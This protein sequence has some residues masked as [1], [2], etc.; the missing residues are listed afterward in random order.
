M[1]SRFVRTFSILLAPLVAA[2]ALAVGVA[3]AQDGEDKSGFVRFLEEFALDARPK[4]LA[5]G[6]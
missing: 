2:I 3:L 4:S 1:R 5:D 6:F